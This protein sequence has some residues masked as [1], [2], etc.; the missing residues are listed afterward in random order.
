MIRDA[1]LKSS[2]F[3]EV[4]NQVNATMKDYLPFN[5]FSFV[6]KI[7]RNATFSNNKALYKNAVNDL[8]QQILR[9]RDSV[10]R[11]ATKLNVARILGFKDE[12][13]VNE[14]VAGALS[15]SHVRN[16][17]TTFSNYILDRIT[18]FSNANSFGEAINKLFREN[19]QVSNYVKNEIIAW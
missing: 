8:L 4:A 3:T 7:L 16:L 14:L 11:I 2:N 15:D 18:D 12:T 9:S 19:S 13:R 10:K 17:A 6:A 1:V 5:D